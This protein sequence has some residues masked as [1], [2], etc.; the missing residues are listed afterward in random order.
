MPDLSGKIVIV[1]GANSGLGYEGARELARKGALVVLACR[2]PDKGRAALE[3]IRSE[4]P[5]ASLELMELDLASLASVRAF[6]KAFLD[7]HQRLDVLCNN[8]GV[9]ALPK[10]SSA[11]G[12]EMQFGTN[13]L[14]HFALTGLLLETLLATGNS[15]VVT[16]SSTMH[17]IGKMH[18]DDLQWQRR[19]SK[20]GAY[21]QSKL[22]NLLFTYELQ[23]RLDARGASLIATSCHPGYSATNLQ[24]E[25]P[26]MAGSRLLEKGTQLAN[27]LFSQTAAMGALT[28]L[29][30]ATSPDVQ[31]GD[32][33]GPDGFSESWGHPKKVRSNKRSHDREAAA[34]LWE[35]SESLTGVRY[36]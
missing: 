32:Y 31:G 8:A 34:E 35:V 12:F 2:N 9:M 1:T 36:L 21:G 23:R 28:L 29:Y 22:A 27:R 10:R 14:G 25:G 13:H 5:S 33:I 26:R 3:A 16:T 30:A 4:Q 7:K 24:G 6:A 17:R 15:R 18:F 11:D 20:W 19:Y